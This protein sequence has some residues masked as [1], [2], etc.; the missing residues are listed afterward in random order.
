MDAETITCGVCGQMA[1]VHKVRY[2]YEADGDAG[3]PPLD[4]VLIEVQRDVECPV[5]G[6]RTQIEKELPQ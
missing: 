2:I 6:E 5:C 4:H 3:R 1:F